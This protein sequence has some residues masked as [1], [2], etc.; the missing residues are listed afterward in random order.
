MLIGKELES[1]GDTEHC[2]S[3]RGAASWNYRSSGHRELK[4]GMTRQTEPDVSCPVMPELRSL[5][6]ASPSCQTALKRQLLSF[7]Q[8]KTPGDP[9][10]SFLTLKA[11]S[12]PGFV[13]SDPK[14]L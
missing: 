14:L 11:D 8:L 2:L 6:S 7:N 12:D 3:G 4:T 9:T 5:T 10:P 13:I 1:R